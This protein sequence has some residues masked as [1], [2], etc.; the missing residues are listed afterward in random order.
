MLSLNKIH[1][2]R[3]FKF[4]FSHGSRHITFKNPKNRL[5]LTWASIGVQIT[6]AGQINFFF[7]FFWIPSYAKN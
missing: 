3:F 1:H 2:F 5:N 6:I 4:F 7:A